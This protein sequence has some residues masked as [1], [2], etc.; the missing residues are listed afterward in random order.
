M[1]SS[2]PRPAASSRT[3][4]D[5]PPP[6]PPTAAGAILGLAG[7][8]RGHAGD[9]AGRVGGHPHAR[10]QV[11]ARRAAA[12][13]RHAGR[14]GGGSGRQAAPPHWQALGSGRSGPAR[15]WRTSRRPASPVVGYTPKSG[16]DEAQEPTVAISVGELVRCVVAWIVYLARR[17]GS[18]G[19]A[20]LGRAAWGKSPRKAE[21]GLVAGPRAATRM[22][23]KRGRLGRRAWLRDSAGLRGGQAGRIQSTVQRY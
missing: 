2:L 23:A 1:R 14:P 12:P 19:E 16:V 15:L 10:C 3:P 5:V 21:L 11:G 8:P 13:R 7:R 18:S 6:L 17:H 4:V 9:L 22:E 20:A